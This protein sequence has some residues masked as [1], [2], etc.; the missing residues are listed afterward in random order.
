M[1][2]TVRQ[3]GSEATESRNGSP[4]TGGSLAGRFERVRSTTAEISS[5]LSPEDAAVQ[6]MP[7]A[8]P[9]KWHLAHTTWFFETFV[10]E[11]FSDEWVSPNRAPPGA[12][13]LVLQAGRAAVSAA[14]AHRADAPIAGRGVSVPAGDDEV[15]ALP[16]RDE[17]VAEI[18][19]FVE[20][21]LHHEQQHQELM[22]SDVKHLFSCNP[23]G[24]CTRRAGLLHG[25]DAPADGT[26]AGPR[27]VGLSIEH[28]PGMT[29]KR[30]RATLDEAAERWPVQ[31]AGVVHRIGPLAI[32]ERIVWVGVRL[33]ASRC[34]IRCLR[35]H[36]G[37]P[38]NDDTPVEA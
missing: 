3:H 20:L 10:L 30:M 9:A 37:R 2:Q 11:R 32:G 16:A 22:L 1:T 31:R 12:V 8:S 29:E 15:V 7:M 13:Q 6:S 19:G 35:L 17:R 26:G 5:P 21:G 24:R 27:W 34:S 28:Y 33:R 25:D 18:A 38:E 36:H 4:A 14:P 23:L